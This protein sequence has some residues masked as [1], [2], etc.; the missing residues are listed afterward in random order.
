[1][2]HTMAGSEWPINHGVHNLVKLVGVSLPDAIKMAS[3]NPARVI[4]V[5]KTKG[6]LEP[7]KDADIIVIDD[8]LNVHLTLVKGRVEYNPVGYVLN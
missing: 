6:S 2:D 3:L 7:G 8:D 1:M 5:D 4:G